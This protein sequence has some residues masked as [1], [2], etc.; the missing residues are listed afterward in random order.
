MNKIKHILAIFIVLAAIA[1]LAYVLPKTGLENLLPKQDVPEEAVA[2][3]TAAQD[4]LPFIDRMKSELE[5][6]QTQ[7]SKR[8]NRDVWTLGKGRTI[9]NYLLQA[10]RILEKNGGKVLYMEEVFNDNNA[11]QS[12]LLDALDPN[13]DTLHLNLQVSTNIFRD[14]ASY[15]S[16][17]FQ[18]TK[19]NPEIIV[20]L[21]KLDFPYDLLVTPFGMPEG[22]YPDLDRIKDKEIVL[23]LVMESQN[24]DSRYSRMRP[25]RSHHTEEQIRSTISDAKTLI[26][27]TSGIATRFAEQAVEHKPLL[28]AVLNAAKE[29][30][31]WFADLSLNKKSKLLELCPELNMN[32]KILSPYNPSNSSLDDYIHQKLRGAARSGMGAMILPLT[33][34][35]IAKVRTMKEKTAAQGTTLINLSTFMNT[36]KELP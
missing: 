31:L 32:C 35:S 27:S 34:E 4:T 19:L 24:L 21:N 8:K 16:I 1:T 15:L 13:G 2:D 28:Q 11:F 10:Q 26:P 30:G 5:V 6:L 23:W 7:Y 25:I 29:N 22:F 33:L 18:V 12:A 17:S 14:N 3:T 36:N 9:I 20:E